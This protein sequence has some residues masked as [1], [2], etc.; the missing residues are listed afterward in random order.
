[1]KPE[2]MAELEQLHIRL[3]KANH[4]SKVPL[5]FFEDAILIAIDLEAYWREPHL[6]TEIGIAVLDTRDVAEI[7]PGESPL[8]RNWHIHI[9]GN[10][11]QPYENMNLSNAMLEID[12]R[13]G[14]IFGN[15]EVYQLA[16]VRQHLQQKFSVPD[17]KDE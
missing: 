10:H 11:I 4:S 16:L 14:F 17:S 3:P 8:G 13:D 6:I 15:S 1:M 7:A 2:L 9:H 12:N 5:P